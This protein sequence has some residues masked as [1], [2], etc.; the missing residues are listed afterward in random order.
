[1]SD[2]SKLKKIVR[3]KQTT[4]YLLS[5][6]C[7]FVIQDYVTASIYQVDPTTF[8]IAYDSIVDSRKTTTTLKITSKAL[9]L[10]TIGDVHSRQTFASDEVWASQ[11]FYGGSSIVCR[12]QTAH[13]DYRL[14][15][16]GDGYIDVMYTLTQGDTT[17]C[18]VDMRWEI[19]G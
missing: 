10:V 6:S 13:I 4:E 12:N 17:L 5:P 11:F 9:S 14:D 7:R 3:I 8:I 15:M 19:S 1:M 18:T 16:Y 2:I